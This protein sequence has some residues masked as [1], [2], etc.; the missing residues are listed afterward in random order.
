MKK[1]IMSLLSLL[2]IVSMMISIVPATAAE[3]E[4]RIGII[5]GFTGVFASFGDMQRSGYEM[6]LEEVD[7]TVAGKKIR[8]IEE[9]DQ[10]NNELAIT[11]TKKLMEQDKIHVLT[12][13]VSGDEGLAVGDYMKDKEIP[14]VVMY[15]ASEDMTMRQSAPNVIRPTWTGAQPM[16]VFG[17]FVAKELGYKKIYHIGE[18]YSYPYN[19]LGGFKRGFCR[20]GGV[21]VTTVWHPSGGVD[22]FSSI[23]AAIP[24]EGYDAVLYNGAGSDALNFVTAYYELGM[25]LPLIG[26][27]NTF[28]QS[29]LPNMPEAIIGNYSG[30]LYVESLNTPE[31]VDWRA[32]YEEK[33]GRIP[34]AAAEFAYSSMK[35]IIR[36]LE[37]TNGD[38]DPAKLLE[39]MMAVDLTDD[40][41]GPVSIDEN[42]AAVENVYIR[43]V[44]QDDQ[45]RLFNQGL[46]TVEQVS[47]FGPY[48]PETYL[49]QAPDSKDYPGDICADFPVEMLTVEKEY[50]FIPW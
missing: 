31:M 38:T 9:D 10:L 7:Y 28:E 8:I 35:L 40:P 39:A 20:G 50:E 26:Q 15:S 41:R 42:K 46:F 2:I 49:K 27:S 36:A 33:N 32:R 30:H 17:Y 4:I 25:T 23:I 47:Q 13:M 37:A 48:D 14:V 29:D 11:K 24:T 21:E 12:G 5:S 3:E 34:A 44:A 18:D 16:D 19:Q 45:G 1:R 22:D 6:A 43:Q